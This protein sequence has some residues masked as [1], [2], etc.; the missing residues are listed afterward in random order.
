MKTK[1]LS[2]V[3]VSCFLAL[4][5]SYAQKI[6]VSVDKPTID[7]SPVLYGVFFEDINWGADGGL[8]PNMIQNHSFEYYPFYTTRNIPASRNLGYSSFTGWEKRSE[9]GAVGQM[10]V[11][12]GY[13]LA[14]NNLRNLNIIRKHSGEG[15]LGVVNTGYDGISVKAGQTYDLSFYASVKPLFKEKDNSVK[16]VLENGKGEVLASKLWSASEL[17]NGWQKYTASFT[18]SKDAKDGKL[19]ILFHGRCVAWLDMVFF[20]PSETFNGHGLR[21]DLVQAVKDMKPAFM[22]FP[23]GC[24]VHAAEPYNMYIWKETVG[25]V[26][27]RKTYNNMWGYFQSN[28]LGYYE[29]F[30]LCED[31][32]AKPLPVVPVG[33]TC[34]FDQYEA[35]PMDQLHIAIEDA[36]DVVE[37]ANGGVD[38]KWG[39]V[40]AEMGHPAPFN[41]EYIGLGNEE[42]DTAEMRERFPYFVKAFKEKYPEIKLV[43]TS[44][45]GAGIPLYD[46]MCDTDVWS[47]DEHYYPTPEWF[48]ENQHRFDNWD[49]SK[50]KVYVG[51]FASPSNKMY[52][53]VCEASFVLG[54]ERN[55][56][57][58]EM[59]S[60]APL[61]KRYDWGNSPRVPIYFD[62]ERV[63]LQPNYYMQQLFANNLGT[64]VLTSVQENWPGDDIAILASYDKPSGDVIIKIVNVKETAATVQVNLK[65]AGR[66]SAKGTRTLIVGGKDD[67]NT[68][69]EPLKVSPVTTPFRTSSKFNVQVPPFSIQVIRTHTGR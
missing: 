64:Q 15:Y 6:T 27:N 4:G 37:F 40:R 2:F 33:V 39:K 63:V 11:T 22:R 24:I 34:G 61:M 25:P 19:A 47:S 31:I 56:D 54:C 67:L 21:K 45:L 49:R 60:Y 52:N 58:V 8:N 23:G 32:G 68:R 10:I 62:N 20:Q 69:E 26:E 1:L 9:D 7:V 12:G 18:P 65:G 16:V 51:E 38:T 29:Y 66:V 59:L 43:G 17:K 30:V 46:L 13:R 44:G 50:P 14:E 48:A 3:L 53:A 41:L 35:M 55:S 57:I 28:T 42:H 5:T 36:L